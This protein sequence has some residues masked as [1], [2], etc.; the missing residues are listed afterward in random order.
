M[1]GSFK[2]ELKSVELYKLYWHVDAKVFQS[3]TTKG[4]LS[5][6]GILS[7]DNIICILIDVL[8]IAQLHLTVKW[9]L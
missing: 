1:K 6:A 2:L 4:M 9:I 8:K 7:W 5:T 3:K